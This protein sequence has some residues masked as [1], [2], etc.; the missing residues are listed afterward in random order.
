MGSDNSPSSYVEDPEFKSRDFKGKAF[1]SSVVP[2]FSGHKTFLDIGAKV[3][4][5][6]SLVSCVWGDLQTGYNVAL[7]LRMARK[8]GTHKG[9]WGHWDI[10]LPK[11]LWQL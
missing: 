11:A 7:L 3:Y 1:V 4:G 6:M 9:I 10:S 5:I 2:C 8:V